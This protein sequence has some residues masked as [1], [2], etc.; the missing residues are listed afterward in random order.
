M[1]GS[2]DKSTQVFEKIWGKTVLSG[3]LT[4]LPNDLLRG[5][6]QLKLSTYDLAVLEHI[7]SVGT[8]YASAKSIAEAQGI[9][10]GTVRKSIK[11]LKRLGYVRIIYKTG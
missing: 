11:Y 7:M 10:I 3:G 8:G 1:N 2:S 4:Q 5:A 6:N 9:S